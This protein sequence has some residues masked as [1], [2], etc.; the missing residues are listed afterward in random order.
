MA[1]YLLLL[2]AKGDKSLQ[3]L[4]L[5]IVTIVVLSFSV[6]AGNAALA[7]GCLDP[8]ANVGCSIV[9]CQALQVNVNSSCKNPSPS[10]CN[11][12]EGCSELTS[13]KSRWLGCYTARNIINGR[14]YAGGDIG[15]QMAAASAISHVGVCDTRI[16]LPEP[17]G[18]ADPC[19]FD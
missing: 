17:V 15:H 9:E 19:P 16:A 5:K 8:L 1:H 7:R 10:S 3:K 13:M 14:C 11:N 6:L 18:C 2:V 12:I 4:L